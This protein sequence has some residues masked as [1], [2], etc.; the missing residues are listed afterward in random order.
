M[1]KARAPRSAANLFGSIQAMTSGRSMSVAETAACE[2]EEDLLQRDFIGVADCRLDP[3]WRVQR[4][5]LAAVHHANA[6][7]QP[8]GLLQYG[9]WCRARSC[10]RP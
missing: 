2:V 7:A 1:P 5:E 8:V 6:V 4:D 10:P 9:A 3:C